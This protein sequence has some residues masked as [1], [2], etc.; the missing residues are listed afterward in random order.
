MVPAEASR[1]SASDGESGRART[2][3]MGDHPFRAQCIPRRR[4]REHIG[5]R[6]VLRGRH[7]TIYLPGATGETVFAAVVGGGRERRG[8]PPGAADVDVRIRANSDTTMGRR[9]TRS[10]ASSPPEHSSWA[11][12]IH[13]PLASVMRRGALLIPERPRRSRAIEVAGL[14]CRQRVACA[15]RSLRIQRPSSSVIWRLE[16]TT[17]TAQS[18]V[19]GTSVVSAA[20]I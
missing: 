15:A 7:A 2:W 11:S 14:G 10:L 3:D 20:D 6:G 1:L 19:D 16:T 13:C 5:G 4:R 18:T 8:E 9:P 17:H 12:R